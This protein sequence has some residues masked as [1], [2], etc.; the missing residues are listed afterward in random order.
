MTKRTE[1][2]KKPAAARKAGKDSI[3][4]MLRDQKAV[5]AAERK[6]KAEEKEREK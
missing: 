5:A 6:R 4:K 1:D 2:V 3:A